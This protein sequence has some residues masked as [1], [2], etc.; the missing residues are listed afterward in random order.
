[1]FMFISLQLQALSVKRVL[2]SLYSSTE[3]DN[4]HIWWRSLFC[5]VQILARIHLSNF[6]CIFSRR[7][8]KKGQKRYFLH[9]NV[10]IRSETAMG[11]IEKDELVQ[12]MGLEST[13]K[14]CNW[15]CVL[16]SGCWCRRRRRRNRRLSTLKCTAVCLSKLSLLPLF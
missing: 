9:K 16:L 10:L 7:P 2:G 15:E 12:E 5:Q 13:D 3:K 11:V 6:S 4:G 1:M 14:T 8:V